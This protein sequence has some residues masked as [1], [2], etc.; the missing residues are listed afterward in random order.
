MIFLIVKGLVNEFQSFNMNINKIVWRNFK[1]FK[2]KIQQF[3][4]KYS[5][6]ISPK[7]ITKAVK[8]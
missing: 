3:F 4:Q 1:S 2:K 5:R 6:N 8:K 7:L